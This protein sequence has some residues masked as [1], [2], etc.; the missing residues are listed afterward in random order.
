MPTTPRSTSVA[1]HRIVNPLPLVFWPA[2]RKS[3]PRW[4]QIGWN[5]MPRKQNSSG[6]G[7]RQQLSKVEEACSPDGLWAISH[8]DGKGTGS[9]CLHRQGADNGGSREQYCTQGCHFNFFLGGKKN[10]Y[11][12]MP[13]DY[14]KIGKNSTLYVVIWR[15]SLF[16]SFLFLFFSL[17]FLFFLF[18]SFF[19]FLFPWGGGRRP[20]S[21]PNDA[22]D[23]TWLHVSTPPTPQ[24]QVVL[25]LDSR[26][27]LA[28]ASVASCID[29]CNGVLY[30]WYRESRN[31][32][33][34]N[35][36]ERCCETSFWYGGVQ[37][38]HP[39]PTWC[40]PLAPCTL[41]SIESAT[42]SPYWL[43]NIFTASVR[44]ISVTFALRWLQPLDE[45][46]CVQ[47]REAI[48]WSL[49]HEQNR[50][51]GQ[52]DERTRGRERADERKNA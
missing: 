17:F 32:E 19:F 37:P 11:F 3:N 1:P 29:Y 51:N 4:A 13:P 41:Y 48:F 18:F 9:R 47:R 45:P 25:T 46:T 16:P 34:S 43:E 22:S 26:R 42:K 8:A 33:T 30:I 44:P 23:C 20:P 31:S 14:W 10:F 24:R 39:D 5:W 15:Y 52:T 49:E 36:F 7:T 12:S 50:A 27:A 6:F 38:R 2:Y 40:P 28:T 21:P 35:G